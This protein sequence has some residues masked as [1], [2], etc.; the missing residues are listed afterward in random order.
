MLS[1][2]FPIGISFAYR[3]FKQRASGEPVIVAFP[4]EGSGYEVEANALMKKPR[5]K[6][7]AKI[8][9][10]WA[11]SDEAITLYAK[12]YPIVATDIAVDAPD[13]W[14]AD[15]MSVLIDN[16]LQWAAKN[17]KRILKEWISR[18]DSKSAPKK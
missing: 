9:L 8:F 11:I 13:G 16:D 3:G 6:K 17:R 1:G 12:V 10:D 5:I 15:P 14:P 4:K 7:E 2:K 18:Y